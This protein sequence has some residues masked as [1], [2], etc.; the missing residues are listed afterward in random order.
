MITSEV[1]ESYVILR[2]PA[3][4]CATFEELMEQSYALESFAQ[5]LEEDLAFDIAFEATSGGS[6]DTKAS[7]ISAKYRSG[8][9]KIKAGKKNKNQKMLAEGKREVEEASSELEQ[10]EKDAKTPE[11]KKK[12]STAA[13]IAIGVGGAA[14]LALMAYVGFKN[15]DKIQGIISNLKRNK[16]A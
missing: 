4:T 1:L 5:S 14:L 13:K 10:A 2:Y 15:K 9:N 16:G 11:E 6:T 7:E 8:F 12:L 3:E